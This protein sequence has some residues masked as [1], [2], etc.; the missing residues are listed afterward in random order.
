MDLPDICPT[1]EAILFASGDSVP[2]RRIAQVLGVSEEEVNAAAD[3][4]ADDYAFRR[5][6]IRLTRM[7]G[8]LQLCSAP[9]FS[10]EI[11]RTLEK[12]RQP[13]L[14][15]TALEVLSIVAYFQPVTR[16]YVEQV[17]GVDSSYTVSALLQRGL[18]E[19][20]GHLDAPGRPTLFR[21]GEAFL[22][23]MGIT[24]LDELP[25]LPDAS[26][27]EGLRQLEAAVA[28]ADKGGQMEIPL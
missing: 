13:R 6:G 23:C 18:I 17:R 10:D 20:C 5:R 22:R 2:A 3:A 1:V 21:T 12:R 24:S 7:E 4:M 27:N 25:P 16:A 14:T 11:T 8:N 28:A 9:E 15:Q 19:E 26:T